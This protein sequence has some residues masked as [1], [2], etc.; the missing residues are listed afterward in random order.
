MYL[1]IDWVY[2]THISSKYTLNIYLCPKQL[3]EISEKKLC[4]ICPIRYSPTGSISSSFLPHCSVW[5][6][7]EFHLSL[8]RPTSERIPRLRSTLPLLPPPRPAAAAPCWAWLLLLP[9][10]L[11]LLLLLALLLPG[12]EEEASSA[13]LAELGVG[14]AALLVLAL[15]PVAEKIQIFTFFLL[16]FEYRNSF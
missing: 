7:S 6:R 13:G 11:S 10:P 14:W 15:G 3:F 12:R 4:K 5:W 16:S 2:N 8:S 9:F 1:R